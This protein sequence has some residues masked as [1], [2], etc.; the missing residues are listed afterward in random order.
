MIS[1]GVSNDSDTDT[2]NWTPLDSYPVLN[3]WVVRIANLAS[4]QQT[5]TVY[6]ICAPVTFNGPRGSVK[7]D[8]QPTRIR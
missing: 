1:G 6:A 8:P 3:Y 4:S 5:F 7:V 2:N